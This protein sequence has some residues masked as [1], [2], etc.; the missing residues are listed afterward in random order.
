MP[1]SNNPISMFRR[2]AVENQTQRLE[3]DVII[4]QPVATSVLVIGLAIVVVIAVVFLSTASFARKETVTG[5]LEPYGG[6]SELVADRS[7]LVGQ[8]LVENNDRVEAGQP[9]LSITSPQFLSSGPRLQEVLQQALQTQKRMIGQRRDGLRLKLENQLQEIDAQISGNE[10]MLDMTTSRIELVQEAL[11]INEGRLSDLEKLSSR[12]HLATSEIESQ[13]E[14]LLSVQRQLSELESNRRQ[15]ELQ[16]VRLTAEK[17]RLPQEIELQLATLSSELAALEQQEAELMARGGYTLTAPIAGTVS[18]LTVGSGNTVRP[19]QVLLRI[20]PEDGQLRAVLLLPTRA[21]GF[22]ATGQ[23]VNIRYEAFP[24]QSFGLHRGHIEAYSNTIRLPN[25]LGM[26]VAVEEPVYK[27][28]VSLESQTVTA[29]G[30]D[31]QLRS[32]MVLSADIVLEERSVIEWLFQPL[33]SLRG[34]L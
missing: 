13:K 1:K 30:H 2:Q 24:Y 17:D 33:F 10:E 28:D 23:P 7:G 19:G 20:L 5:Y 32:G 8:L 18:D 14:Q 3:G 34:Q 31:T 26:P 4:A 29:F 27:V 9:L 22:V 25:E 6:V 12:G 11:K 15:L 21:M 16:I